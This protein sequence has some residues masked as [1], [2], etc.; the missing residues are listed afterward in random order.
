MARKVA[1]A[2]LLGITQPEYR[3]K[4]YG[5]STDIKKIPNLLRSFRD[6]KIVLAGVSLI[7]DLG[8]KECFD[9]VEVWSS[10]REALKTLQVWFEKKG[11]E[12]TGVI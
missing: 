2:Y 11:M 5:C 4:A 10:N 3:M 12:T 1:E 9:S 8:V 6:K 7:S